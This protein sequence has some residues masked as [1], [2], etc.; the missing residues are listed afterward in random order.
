M[1]DRQTDKT[2]YRLDANFLDESSKKNLAF[3]LQHQTRKSHFPHSVTEWLSTSEL[4]SIIATKNIINWCIPVK[5][6]FEDIFLIKSL[7]SSVPLLFMLKL[8]KQTNNS[9]YNVSLEK[10]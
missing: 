2:M 10:F 6:F 3:Y 8:K 5:I 7:I 9:F 1:T 4:Y